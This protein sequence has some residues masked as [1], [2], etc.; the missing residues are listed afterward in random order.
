MTRGKGA[1]R[2]LAIATTLG[3]SLFGCSDRNSAVPN[4]GPPVQRK[5]PSLSQAEVLRIA[6]SA[7]LKDGMKLWNY[8][9]PQISYE[10]YKGKGRWIAFYQGIEDKPENFFNVLIDDATGTADVSGNESD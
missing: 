5:G 8:D 10:V 3:A 6:Q 1:L 4:A 7:A 2:T 9:P